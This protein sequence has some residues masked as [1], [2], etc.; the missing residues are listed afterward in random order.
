MP[1]TF[2][3]LNTA[4][5]GL[6]A[7]N[8]ALNTTANNISNV[9]TKGYS[10]QK[11]VQQAA[12]ALRTFTTYGC[13]G[14]GVDTIAIER[15]RDE[16]YD[17]RYW[18]NNS[19]LGMVE[20]KRYYYDL[21]EDY[22]ADDTTTKGFSTIFN[23]MYNS[24]EELRKD[25]GSET[26]KTNFFGFANNLVQYFKDISD[27][28]KK[29]QQDVN[30]EIEVQVDA[31]NS[32]AEQIATFNKQINTIEMS[33]GNAN[34]LRDQRAVLLDDLSKIVAVETKEVPIYDVNNP[35]RLTGG[36]NFQVFIAGGDTL[37]NG[38]AYY[39]L[40]CVARES[41]ERVY[42]SDADGLYDIYWSN[43]NRFSLTN[44]S[45]G[46]KMQGLI[47]V[48]DGNNGAYFNGT[49]T[50]VGTTRIDGK[51]YD[52]VTVAVTADYLKDITRCTLSDTG[53]VINLGNQ[54]YKYDSW[55][56][57]YD[58][59]TDSYS[60]TFTMSDDNERAVS[61]DRINKT[62]SIGNSQYF[63]GVPYYQEQ[64]N[65][66]LR[67]FSKAFNDILTQKGSVDEY[68][69]PAQMFFLA[70]KIA[71]SGQFTFGQSYTTQADPDGDGVFE[72]V[73]YSIKST[74]DSYFRMT[75]SNFS[76][77]E[78]ILRDP[79][80]FATHTGATSGQDAYDVLDDL[81]DLETNK[82][83]MTFRG[84]SSSE[85]LQCILS[86]VGLVANQVKTQVGTYEKI[87][88]TVDNM[89]VSISG[90]DEDEEAVDLVKYQN[91]YN[92]ASKMIQTLTECYDRLI[93]Q[94][95]V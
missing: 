82:D 62:A 65:E 19:S 26:T 48:R 77:N 20:S 35:D 90:V 45:M 7:S 44:P 59:A 18:E 84:C 38:N 60:Y 87:G 79:R 32:I 23:E 95:G 36:Y 21:F 50:G 70:D 89:R 54:R 25:A 58:V 5:T 34:E 78:A 68:G 3:G 39:S 16:F 4:Y 88:L 91:A 12:D 8:A 9:D 67:N 76:I 86:D 11:V 73:S 49:I 42:Q 47:E 33:G 15:I 51:P 41:D 13:A 64:A 85:F 57:D 61:S 80:L 29:S 22:F 92:L 81:L 72:N 30:A 74:D 6:L 10:R 75:A 53:G 14:A 83:R 28:L 66:F 2:F 27:N 63:Q 17:V 43:G 1:S 55:S 56:F 40:N 93:L 46:G 71:E 94:T 37:V 24:L 31:I 52:T 69:N